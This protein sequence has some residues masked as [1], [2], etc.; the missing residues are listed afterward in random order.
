[1][2]KKYKPKEEITAWNYQFQSKLPTKK[3]EQD[4]I[5]NL[6]PSQKQYTIFTFPSQEEMHPE[7]QCKPVYFKWYQK[8]WRKLLNKDDWDL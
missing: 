2:K 5:K 7:I 6:K 8:I 1:M 4:F 3:E